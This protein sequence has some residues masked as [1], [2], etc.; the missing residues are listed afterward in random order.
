MGTELPKGF[1]NRIWKAFS[2]PN[3][4]AGCCW[5]V[6]HAVEVF[7]SKCNAILNCF[8]A[9]DQHVALLKIFQGSMLLYTAVFWYFYC[10][11]WWLKHS[12]WVMRASDPKFTSLRPLYWWRRIIIF[13]YHT[14]FF[15]KC[16]TGSLWRLCI[17]SAG[18]SGYD[19]TTG[20][21]I[22]K[23]MAMR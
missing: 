19:L 11:G 13:E 14:M 4:R 7:I 16:W 15:R 5:I 3:F 17:C 20:N 2:S 6:F 22:T 21:A 9:F 12:E 10:K 23:M 8:T 18:V 1:G